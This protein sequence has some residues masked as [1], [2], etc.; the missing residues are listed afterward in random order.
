MNRRPQASS[1]EPTSAEISVKSDKLDDATIPPDRAEG[2]AEVQDKTIG[3]SIQPQVQHQDLP[4]CSKCNGH[5]SF[6]FWYCIF[7]EGRS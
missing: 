5:L 3:D 6:P 4:T 1:P 2:A 7:C